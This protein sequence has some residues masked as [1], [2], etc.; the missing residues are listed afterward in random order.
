MEYFDDEIHGYMGDNHYLV[1]IGMENVKMNILVILFTLLSIFITC[2]SMI[3]T[4]KKLMK[5]CD[6]KAE[7]IMSIFNFISKLYDVENHILYCIVYRSIIFYTSEKAY[8]QVDFYNLIL[9]LV[10]QLITVDTRNIYGFLPILFI[11]HEI[12]LEKRKQIDMFSRRIYITM[13]M[14]ELIY[15][16]YTLRRNNNVQKINNLPLFVFFSKRKSS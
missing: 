14:L 2:K 8:N 15:F 9:S 3:L 6:Y 7:I 5:Y 16:K 12:H 1:D 11:V 10:N 4:K 13:K